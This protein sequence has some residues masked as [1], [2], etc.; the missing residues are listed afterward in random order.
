VLIDVQHNV[1]ARF[2]INR[3]HQMLDRPFS[4]RGEMPP[5]TARTRRTHAPFQ[6]PPGLRGQC[7]EGRR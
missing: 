4:G 3:V 7:P 6:L 2:R 1:I 5:Q